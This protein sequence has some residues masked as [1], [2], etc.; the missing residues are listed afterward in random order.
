MEGGFLRIFL[1]AP[2]CQTTLKGHLPHCT[3]DDH[4]IIHQ[5]CVL[6]GL[7]LT[8]DPNTL[9]LL[10]TRWS[11][12]FPMEVGGGMGDTIMID[13]IDDWDQKPGA[14]ISWFTGV[15]ENTQKFWQKISD[16]LFLLGLLLLE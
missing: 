8:G 4:R 6:G 5:I 16:H 15:R 9:L 14:H 11:H 13:S 12:K 3:V 7:C 10:D 2:R 1:Q